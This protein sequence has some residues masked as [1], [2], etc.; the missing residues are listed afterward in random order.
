MYII[1]LS[2]LRK[3]KQVEFGV[4][5]RREDCR[6]VYVTCRSARAEAVTAVSARG[7]VP[8]GS[9]KSLLSH[10]RD[11]TSHRQAGISS[12]CIDG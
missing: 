1:D 11:R 8:V 12:S 10:Q 4:E 5:K 6:E 9:A 7:E 3:R 2:N